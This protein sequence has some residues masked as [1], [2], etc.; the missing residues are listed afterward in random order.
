MAISYLKAYS[1][2][3]PVS[4]EDKTVTTAALVV[5]KTEIKNAIEQVAR[6]LKRVEDPDMRRAIDPAKLRTMA[7]ELRKSLAALIRVEDVT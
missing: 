6:L 7:L 5:S 1:L 4:T 2:E 3:D